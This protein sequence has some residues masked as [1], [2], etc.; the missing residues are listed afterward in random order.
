MDERVYC[1]ECYYF[2]PINENK[3]HCH[4]DSPTNGYAVCVNGWWCSKGKKI[5][6]V[7]SETIESE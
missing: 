6:V 3:G 5:D 7:E 2:E 1:D 4:F